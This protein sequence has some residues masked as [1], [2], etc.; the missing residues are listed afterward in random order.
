M[1][2]VGLFVVRSIVR[3]RARRL[4]ERV[5]AYCRA[6]DIDVERLRSHYRGEDFYDFFEALFELEERRRRLEG[7]DGDEVSDDTE[8]EL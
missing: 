7:G 4:Y 5:Q 6:N 3:R 8:R 1:A 2:L